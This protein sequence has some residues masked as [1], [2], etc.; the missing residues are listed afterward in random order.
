MLAERAYAS[1]ASAMDSGRHRNRDN[2]IVLRG[3]K[4][5]EKSLTERIQ[6]KRSA[7]ALLRSGYMVFSLAIIALGIE[8]FVWAGSLVGTLIQTDR[9]GKILGPILMACG[10]GVLF[11]RQL[12]T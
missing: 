10:V 1:R 12:R 11:N 4:M 7:D 5:T 3:R 9:F 6:L 2:V 8:T